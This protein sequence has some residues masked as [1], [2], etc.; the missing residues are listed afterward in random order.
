MYL[1]AETV[2]SACTVYVCFPHWLCSSSPF[3]FPQGH[4]YHCFATTQMKL[5]LSVCI[6]WTGLS[7]NSNVNSVNIGHPA[8]TSQRCTKTVNLSS[9]WI[10][11]SNICIRP[12]LL[13]ERLFISHTG[14]SAVWLNHPL[15]HP[16]S[17]DS[18][19]LYHLTLLWASNIDVD[20][21]TLDLGWN[22]D[23]SHADVNEYLCVAMERGKVFWCTGP[24]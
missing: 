6:G 24:V 3:S 10:T 14:R 19:A 8:L 18:L 5:T 4:V 9:S 7:T 20:G 1:C 23:A 15:D 17:A 22:P 21:L 2:H 12:T 13:A 11:L 16:S